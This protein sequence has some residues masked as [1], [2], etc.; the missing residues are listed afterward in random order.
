MTDNNLVIYQK[1]LELTY[2]IND[3][4]RKYPKCERFTLVQEMKQTLYVGLKNLMYAVKIFQKSEKLKYLNEF[5]ICMNLLKIH[6][7]LSYRYKYITTQNYETCSK[8]IA[9][10][11]N[12]LGG[13]IKVCLKK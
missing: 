2:Y 9:D 8:Y 3:L 4:V 6:L 13:W 12:M 5:D 11:C 10:I 1:Y 7:R